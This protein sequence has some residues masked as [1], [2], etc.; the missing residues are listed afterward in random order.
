[1]TFDDFWP[2]MNEF[3][4]VPSAIQ[5]YGDFY[6]DFE[7]IARNAKNAEDFR[8]ALNAHRKTQLRFYKTSL[9]SISQDVGISHSRI[10][11][12]LWNVLLDLLSQN[13][14]IK[15]VDGGLGWQSPVSLQGLI[16]ALQH[17]HPR[18]IPTAPLAITPPTPAA[19]PSA[20]SS[21]P[22]SD[23]SNQKTSQPHRALRPRKPMQNKNAVTHWRVQKRDSSKAKKASPKIRNAGLRQYNLRDHTRGRLETRPIK[24]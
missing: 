16:N 20:D 17:F 23:L 12:E 14:S 21:P 19:S 22:S 10:S 6:N 9:D 11:S 8:K 18:L 2:L 4:T 3:N 7:T 13:P 15:P 1:M 24:Y 5:T